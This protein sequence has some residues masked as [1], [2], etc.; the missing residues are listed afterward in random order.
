METTDHPDFKRGYQI[1]YILCEN[2]PH[3]LENSL[4]GFSQVSSQ[5]IDGLK[6]GKKQRQAEMKIE[7][8]ERERLDTKEY[9][10]HIYQER[11]KEKDYQKRLKDEKIA[12][13]ERLKKIQAQVRKEIDEDPYEKYERAQRERKQKEDA[14]KKREERKTIDPKTKD[15]PEADPEKKEVEKVKEIPIIEM[16]KMQTEIKGLSQ[17]EI[18]MNELS[19]MRESMTTVRSQSRAD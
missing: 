18:R 14:I 3:V 4:S 15:M 17:E 13:E 9:M 5:F 2:A 8:R 1:G 10:K 19:E 11:Q 6:A 16:D 12:K 7:K